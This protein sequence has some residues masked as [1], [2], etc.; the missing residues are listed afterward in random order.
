[1]AGK[2]ILP[3]KTDKNCKNL[4]KTDRICIIYFMLCLCFRREKYLF[5]VRDW[6]SKREGDYVKNRIV[7]MV[8]GV[9]VAVLCLGGADEQKICGTV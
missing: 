9:V 3:F 4:S 5:T 7:K 2:Y 6:K 8:L 1:M